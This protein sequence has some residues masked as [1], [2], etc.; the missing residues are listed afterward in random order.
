MFAP[1]PTPAIYEDFRREYAAARNDYAVP[2]F[3]QR[4]ASDPRF[5]AW[6]NSSHI[7]AGEFLD[8]ALAL[9]KQRALVL[10]PPRSE[11]LAWH[12]RL[13]QLE[14][15]PGANPADLSAIVA[16]ILS[17]E[18]PPSPAARLFVLQHSRGGEFADRVHLIMLL[19]VLCEHGAA[20]SETRSVVARLS[21]D[22]GTLSAEPELACLATHVGPRLIPLVVEAARAAHPADFVPV[23]ARLTGLA[24]PADS[25]A[26]LG[27]VSTWYQANRDQLRLNPSAVYPAPGPGAVFVRP[28]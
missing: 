27:A 16:T 20:G 14:P 25:S 7:R 10:D 9:R 8:C 4:F 23:L 18:P 5:P 19:A 24:A 13:S 15:P 3:V 11:L 6:L 12:D 1:Q 22:P 2:G 17:A 21:E 28:R 26:Y